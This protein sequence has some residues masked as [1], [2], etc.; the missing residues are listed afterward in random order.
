MPL[1]PRI[2]CGARDVPPAPTLNQ[3][4]LYEE[5]IGRE[6]TEW[7]IQIWTVLAEWASSNS[8]AKGF[9]DKRRV[10]DGDPEIRVMSDFA[11]LM[12]MVTELAESA[13]DIRKPQESEKIPGFTG[14]EEEYADLVIRL[15]DLA[16]TRGHRVPQAVLA[17][18]L[19]NTGRPPMHGGKTI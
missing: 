4:A 17:K 12:L 3:E 14:E 11:A 18:M 9:H 6:E 1:T 19:Y 7:W 16:A 5:G 13:E 15:F 10:H 2:Y 8:H